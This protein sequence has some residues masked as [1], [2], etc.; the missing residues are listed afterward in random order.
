MGTGMNNTQDK[1]ITTSIN[2]AELKETSFIKR[3]EQLVEEAK[4]FN[5]LSNVFMS[6]ALNDIPACQ[7]VI[8]VITGMQ[9]LIVKEVRLQ[10]RISKITAHDA[11]LDILAEDSCGRLVNLEIQRKDTI[12]H[13]RRTRFYAA[14]IDSECLGKGKEYYQMP[15]VHIIYI[16]ETD[17][18]SAGKTLYKVEKKFQETEISYDDGIYVTY[19]NAE[20]DDGS[21]VAKLMEYFKTADPEDMSQGDLSARIRFLKCEEG[22]YSEMCEVSERIYKEGMIEGKKE[23]KKEGIIEGKKETALNMKKK[24]YSD[25]IIADI[26]EVGINIIQQ[27][28]GGSI[29]KS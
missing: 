5:L 21:D 13:A 24:G 7:H 29:A 11:I 17:L 19:V 9:E 16:S 28:L 26:L 18:W 3:R 4:G 14:M 25:A 10:H 12:D 27:W 20:V 2:A 22:G 1:A 15:D 23:G 6:V 8:R